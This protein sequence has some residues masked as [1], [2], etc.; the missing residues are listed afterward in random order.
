MNAEQKRLEENK[1]PEEPWHF[2]GPY[3][4]ERAWGTVR[5]DYSANGD[6]WN[7]FPHDHA[8]SR[9]Y[10][11]NEDGIGG[12]SD[13]KGRLCFAFAFW[14]ERDP[15]LKERI[16][17]VSGP[18]GNHGEDVKELYWYI[19]S[20]PSHSF[21]RM[22]YRYPQSRFP[23]EE[24][25][26]ANNGRS[27]IEGEFKIWNTNAFAESRYFDIELEYAKANAHDVLIR[28]N[29]RNCGPEAAPLH[30]LPT[31]WFR[32]TWSWGRDQAKPSLRKTGGD[33]HVAIIT[34]SH[35]IL[36]DY[37]LIC[38]SL[39]DLFFTENESNAE[40]LWGIQNAKPFVKDSINDCVVNG[41]IDIVNSAQFGTKVAAHY[42]FNIPAAALRRDRRRRRG[43]AGAA[44]NDAVV[45]SRHRV[46][47]G[48][49][50]RH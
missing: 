45:E 15:F 24:L 41:K 23:Y 3:L 31:I 39:D 48:S 20:T 46:R 9:A 19:D 10:R 13:H 16:F 50:G 22:I 30:L 18:E 34:A 25:V 43:N 1:T 8:R 29:A 38:D 2:W 21:M 49:R 42:K 27:K 37:N 5:E 6:A 11:W 17:G 35:P 28:V 4:A 7:Y 36:G 32:N 26:A 47:W 12:I 14:N 33:G 40:R 44:A